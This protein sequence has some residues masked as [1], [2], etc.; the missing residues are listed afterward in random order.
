MDDPK[1]LEL[2]TPKWYELMEKVCVLLLIVINRRI[3][4]EI[5]LHVEETTHAMAV[6][7]LLLKLTLLQENFAVSRSSSNNREIKCFKKFGFFSKRI[8]PDVFS[9]FT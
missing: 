5:M 8:F 6:I 9:N 4:Q 2:P 7:L 3:S 1:Q